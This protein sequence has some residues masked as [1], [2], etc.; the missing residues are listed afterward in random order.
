VRW[1]VA[2]AACH[3]PPPPL[4]NATAPCAPHAFAAI[5][6]AGEYDSRLYATYAPAHAQLVAGIDASDRG[7]VGAAT[8]A[9][10]AC[11]A[12]F[13]AIDMTD[14]L[15]EVATDNAYACYGD[16]LAAHANHGGARRGVPVLAEAAAAHP[17]M[18]A[19]IRQII[20]RWPRDCSW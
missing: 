8:A 18:A 12:M 5:E 17:N 20:E 7:D 16:V 13:D 14:P 3:P 9:F 10:L 19:S 2:L 1:L 15:R 11:A 6:Q 4:A